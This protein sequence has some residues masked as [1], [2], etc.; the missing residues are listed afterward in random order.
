MSLPGVPP[1]GGSLSGELLCSVEESASGRTHAKKQRIEIGKHF[2]WNGDDG[3]YGNVRWMRQR[4]RDRFA[5]I[6]CVRIPPTAFCFVFFFLCVCN[7]GAS[8][9]ELIC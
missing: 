1:P 2:T 7:L 6:L 8:G 3:A 5:N 4:F 9:P